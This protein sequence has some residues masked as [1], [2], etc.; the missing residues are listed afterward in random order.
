MAKPLALASPVVYLVRR[1]HLLTRGWFCVLASLAL[2]GCRSRAPA[3]P[4]SQLTAPQSVTH[5]ASSGARTAGV[6]IRVAARGGTPRAYRL[7]DLVE[8]PNAIHGKLPAVADVIGLD[9]E[10]EFLFVMTDKKDVLSLDLGSGRVDTVVTAIV[11]AALGPD[12]TPPSCRSTTTRAH[13]S[14]PL[15]GTASMWP[16]APSRGS[17]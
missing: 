10:S 8:I 2:G 4:S 16:D 17:P 3:D 13:L 12:G 5:A 9:P 14:S 7:P 11:Q 1:G 6:A 15:P